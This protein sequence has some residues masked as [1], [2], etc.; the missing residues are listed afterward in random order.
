MNRFRFIIKS[1]KYFIKQHIAVFLATMISTAVLTGALIVGD[2]VKYSLKKLVDKRLG[3]IEYIMLGGDRFFRSELS[4]EISKETK[5]PAASMLMLQG[6]AINSDNQKR[7]NKAQI[8]GID[9]NFWALSDI[10]MPSISEKEVIISQNV[11]E[12]LN[13]KTG[14]ELLI[15]MQNESVIP[16]NAPFTSDENTGIA[17]RLTIKHIATQDELGRFSLRN[18][19]AAPY[20]IFINKNT[21]AS[22]LQLENLSNIILVGRSEQINEDNLDESLRNNW[23]LKDAGLKIHKLNNNKFELLSDRIFIDI[24]ITDGVDKTKIPNEK[25]LSYFVNSLKINKKETPYSFITAAPD[26]F[27]GEELSDSEIIINSWLANDLNAKVGDSLHIKYFVMGSLRSLQ[28]KSESF[29]VKSIVPIADS[30]FNKNLMPDFPGLSDAGN[31][32]DWD[33]GIPI[34]LRK[35]RDKDEDYWNDYRGTP[36]AIIS[37]ERGLKLWKNKFGSYTA[38]RF[39]NNRLS[40]SELEQKII[41]GISPKDLGLMFINLRSQGKQAASNGVDFGE[42]FLSL[43]FFVIAAAILLLVLIYSL[44]SESRMSEVGMLFGLGFSKKQILKLRFSESILTIVLGAIFGGLAGISYNNF[45][46]WGLNSIWNDA[47]HAD[48][49]EVFVKPQTLLTGIFIGIIISLITIYLVTLRKLKKTVI[50]IIAKQESNYKI[51]KARLNKVVAFGGIFS[52]VALLLFSFFNSIESNSQ[53]MLIAGFLFLVGST[54]LFLVFLKPKLYKKQTVAKNLTFGRLIMMNAGRNISRSIAVVSLLALGTFTIIITGAN[55]TTF[56]GTENKRES[57]TGGFKLWVENTVPILQNLN[58]SDGKNQYGLEDENILD[59]VRFVQ[60]HNL[61]GDDASCLNLNQVQQPQIL[62][63][64]PDLFDSLK[65]FSFAK[66][67]NDSDNPWMQLNNNYG[68]NI[69]PAYADQTV[70]QW[71]LIK[72]VGDTLFYHNEFGEE[73]S[74][75]LI[76]GLNSSVFQGNILISIE[77]FEKNFPSSGGSKIMLVDAPKENLTEVEDLLNNYLS[78]YGIEITST[79]KRLAAFYSVTNTYLSIFMI[80]GGLGVIL[81]TFGLGIVLMRNMLERKQEIA[82]FKALGFQNNQIFKLILS[83]NLI[84]LIIG[85]LIGFISAFIGILPS[86]ISPAF[87]IPGNFLF[88]IVLIVFISGLIW[89]LIPA[90][91]SMKNNLIKNLRKE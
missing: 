47:V 2:S 77:N 12:K 34:D 27:L 22:D 71:G 54:S 43:S 50:S 21:V 32:S 26:S 18:N 36:K 66:L 39:E 68:D 52:S 74:I 65:A 48:S 51:P 81:G 59:D 37:L 85:I 33:T 41:S 28:E 78:D 64:N 9:D 40:K 53:L 58:T 46:I 42:L 60:F 7:I 86:I 19:Q 25:I 20:N 44:N 90:W 1:F 24:P 79:S 87:H 91:L 5:L 73:L 72:S 89:I 88:V 55:R 3:N 70:I 45:M 49:I 62:G 13:L 23:T 57:G 80:L 31:C 8:L 11:S 61:A 30:I 82:T 6:I 56:S 76:G 10:E 38:I 84:L 35:I 16:L 69:I 75:I 15:R 67:L 14:D 17:L 63:V 83:E 29:I 4:A